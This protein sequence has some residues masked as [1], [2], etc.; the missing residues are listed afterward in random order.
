MGIQLASP[1]DIGLMKLAAISSRGTRRDFVDI[2]CMRE[3]ISLEDLF[4]LAPKKYADRPQFLAIAV[5]ALAYFEDAEQ[6]PMPRMLISAEWKEIR[7]YCE[8]ASRKL[9]RHFSGLS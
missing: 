4:K 5:R 7:K 6:Q 3:L 9:T 1:I 2:Y 8:E